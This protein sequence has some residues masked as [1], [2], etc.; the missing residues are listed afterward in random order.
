MWQSRLM[1]L[2]EAVVNVVVGLIVAVTTQ[3]VVFPGPGAARESRAE[4]QA[5]AGLHRRVGGAEL[6]TATAVRALPS[7]RLAEPVR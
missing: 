5:R 6:W 1:S 2:V 3:I 7:R 4:L